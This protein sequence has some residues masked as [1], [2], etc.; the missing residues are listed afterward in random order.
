MSTDSTVRAVHRG[1]NEQWFAVAV[2]AVVAFV[3]SVVLVGMVVELSRHAVLERLPAVA[4]IMVFLFVCPLTAIIAW[5]L[6][7]EGEWLDR[8]PISAVAVLTILL[9][10]VGVLGRTALGTGGRLPL[11]VQQIA[12][13][14]AVVLMLLAALAAASR[15][16]FGW[17]LGIVL[18]VTL[19]GLCLIARPGN[20]ALVPGAAYPRDWPEPFVDL[21]L[22]CPVA[23]LG[24]R[25]GRLDPI[26]P[27]IGPAIALLLFAFSRDSACVALLIASVALGWSVSDEREGDTRPRTRRLVVIAFCVVG[28]LGVVAEAQLARVPGMTFR[29]VFGGAGGSWPS[30][31]ALAR[32]WVGPVSAPRATLIAIPASRFDAQLMLF[33]FAMILGVLAVLL[34]TVARRIAPGVSRAGATGLAVF[35]AAQCAGWLLASLRLPC[36]G[37]G[38]PLLVGSVTWDAA[39]VIAIGVIVGLAA[40]NRA[41]IEEEIGHGG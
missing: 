8:M 14:G 22:I 33:G 18:G 6:Q 23:W 20:S 16:Q 34:V 24:G 39:D 26:R 4:L 9:A 10:E 19:L 36:F 37:L 38:A 15:H 41:A 11:G 13:A 5:R 29:S 35:V 7:A 12:V 40:R 3:G 2:V 32:S 30:P 28:L 21:A 27:V 17:G 25:R 1:R 31:Y